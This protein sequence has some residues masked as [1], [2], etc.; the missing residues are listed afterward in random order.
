MRP[1]GRQEK[2][3]LKNVMFHFHFPVRQRLSCLTAG[4]ANKQGDDCPAYFPGGCSIL[5][6]T[7]QAGSLFVSETM[8]AKL[9]KKSQYEDSLSHA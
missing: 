4:L 2:T 7:R 9:E 8:L 5:R 3:S 6:E 1:R